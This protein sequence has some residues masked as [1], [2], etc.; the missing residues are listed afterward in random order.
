M[1]EVEAAEARRMEQMP[2]NMHC[3]QGNEMWRTKIS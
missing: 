3:D 2:A 1:S